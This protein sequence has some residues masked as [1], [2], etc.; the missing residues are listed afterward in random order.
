MAMRGRAEPKNHNPT[1][2]IYCL[3]TFSPIC[4]LYVDS[5]KM[6]IKFFSVLKDCLTTHSS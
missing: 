3:E 6:T 5:M 2:H 1:L 4:L